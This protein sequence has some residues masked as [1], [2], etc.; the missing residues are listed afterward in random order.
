MVVD[1]LPQV[2]PAHTANHNIAAVAPILPAEAVADI[3]LRFPRYSL[4]KCIC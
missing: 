1:P 3:V 4:K 2:A